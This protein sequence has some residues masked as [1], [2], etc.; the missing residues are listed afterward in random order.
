MK[1]K[2]NEIMLQEINDDNYYHPKVYVRYTFQK[3][4]NLG[5]GTGS[6]FLLRDIECEYNTYEDMLDL[7]EA[8]KKF[9]NY[10]DNTTV[11]ID[12]IRLLDN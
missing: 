10:S 7:V 2:T 4:N 11:I 5:F 1:E 6:I 3:E 9:N 12:Y 8:I